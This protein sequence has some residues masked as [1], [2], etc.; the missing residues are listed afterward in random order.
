MS[1]DSRSIP[2]RVL[3]W[4]RA[5]Y[6]HGVPQQDYIALLGILHRQLTE[7]E[8][9][10]VASDLAEQAAPNAAITDASIRAM[11]SAHVLQD[12]DAESITRVA[13]H[14]AWGGWPLAD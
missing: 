12:A 13:A 2:R 11:I 8:I 5:G 4:L 6:P 7:V 10:E 9:Q 1:N 14:L 3:D